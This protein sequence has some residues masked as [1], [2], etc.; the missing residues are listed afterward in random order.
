MLELFR[1][2]KRY[3]NDIRIRV[4]KELNAKGSNQTMIAEKYQIS[5][6]TVTRIKKHY[7]EKGTV[8]TIRKKSN[9]LA[10]I[11]DLDE[12]QKF[13]EENNS[14]IASELAKKWGEKTKTRVCASTIRNYL[15]KINFSR[16]K[17]SFFFRQNA[18]C[19]R[20]TSV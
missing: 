7:T 1:R 6:S 4:V 2:G 11:I 15:K 16:K 8:E 14:L 3:S 18:S 9:T 5:S 19:R 12:F 17:I 13:I 20:N 10:K